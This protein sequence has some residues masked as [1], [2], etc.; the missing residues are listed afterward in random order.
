MG[1]F[2]QLDPDITVIAPEPPDAFNGR[3]WINSSTSVSY[4]YDGSREKWQSASDSVLEYSY[5]GPA[6][7][8][9]LKV[10]DISH[11]EYGYKFHDDYT[12]TAID[13]TGQDA[14]VRYDIVTSVSG[15]DTL[16]LSFYTTDFVYD[17]TT[18]NIDVDRDN[19]LKIFSNKDG[20]SSATN[21]I[22]LLRKHWRYDI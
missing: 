11:S 4:I 20:V 8:R 16:E 12:V 13:A 3:L 6:G 2:T 18:I 21:P 10:G 22:C 17:S 7:N 5:A 19:I 14:D 15:I 1:I 9:Y